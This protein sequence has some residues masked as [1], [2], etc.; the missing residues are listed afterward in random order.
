MLSSTPRAENSS[1]A[2]NML[3]EY[4]LPKRRGVDTRISCR[5]DSHPYMSKTAL[6]ARANAPAPSGLKNVRADARR[7]WS[8]NILYKPSHL[9]PK[10][11][12]VYL[13]KRPVELPGRVDR[14][15]RLPT[16]RNPLEAVH[17][18]GN[19]RPPGQNKTLKGA[20]APARALFS[21]R[22]AGNEVLVVSLVHGPPREPCIHRRRTK[23]HI[24]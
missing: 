5:S 9:P 21:A 24:K 1:A 10:K 2:A 7:K 15:K 14:R 4:V 3:T 12:T 11:L 16:Q 23:K 20:A 8:W 18:L 17:L 13:V 19:P 22:Q 6:C